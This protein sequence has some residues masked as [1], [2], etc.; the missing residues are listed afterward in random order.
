[1]VKYSILM[2]TEDGREYDVSYFIDGRLL[3][4]SV[5]IEGLP[6]EVG[7]SQTKRLRESLE[8]VPNPNMPHKGVL[9]FEL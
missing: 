8:G 9:E 4:E 3:N 6:R 5:E 2:G 1:M 7:V